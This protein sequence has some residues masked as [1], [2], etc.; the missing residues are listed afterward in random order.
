MGEKVGVVTSTWIYPFKGMQG[1]ERDEIELRSISVV[2]DRSRKFDIIDTSETPSFLDTLKFK[3]L[4]QYKP[5]LSDN[6]HPKTSPLHVITPEGNDYLADSAELVDEIQKQTGKKLTV[7]RM[8]RAA[9]HSMPVSLI[10]DSSIKAIEKKY[11]KEIDPRQF[12]MNVYIETEVGLPYEEENWLGK[13][14]TFGERENSAKIL[15]FKLDE[16]CATINL[17]PE[18]GKVE[19]GVLKALVQEHGKTFPRMSFRQRHGVQPHYVPALIGI[20]RAASS[21]M[22]CFLFLPNNFKFWRHIFQIFA[23]YNAIFII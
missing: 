11:G 5:Y 15:G 13:V 22:I 16:R 8:G 3:E 10:S 6:T 14:I 21:H 19:A 7:V 20:N 1:I 12:R 2:G 4:L 9:Y 18:T 23:K 17:H